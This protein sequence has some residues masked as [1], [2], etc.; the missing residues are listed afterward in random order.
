MAVL[1]SFLSFFCT[2]RGVLF[3]HGLTERQLLHTTKK[4]VQKIVCSI[5]M[6]KKCER[7]SFQLE[8]S[9]LHHLFEVSSDH[10]LDARR[11]GHLALNGRANFLH[12]ALHHLRIRE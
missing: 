12:Q 8:E 3:T 11:V 5:E 1:S 2:L 9:S 7:Y 4:V 10:G 6:T